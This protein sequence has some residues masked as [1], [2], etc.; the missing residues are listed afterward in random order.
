MTLADWKSPRTRPHIASND[1]NWIHDVTRLALSTPSERLRIES[2][3]LL[4]GVGWP[5]ASV[6]L[7]FC[8]TD[9]YPILDFRALWALGAE[10]PEYDFSFWQTYTRT[11]RNLAARAAC[12]M[13]T[14]DRAL[15]AYSKANQR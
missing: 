1:D 9:P 11:C 7:H 6:I 8:H 3:T 13:R 15:W 2:L 4:R 10:E 12:D 5:M 14:L